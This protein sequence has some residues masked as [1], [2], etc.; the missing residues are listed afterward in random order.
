MRLLNGRVLVVSV[1][2]QRG[3][4]GYPVREG[5]LTNQQDYD[6]QVLQNPQ[7]APEELV[8]IAAS[9][10]DLWNRILDH[11]SVYPELTVWI[12]TKQ[13]KAT[14]PAQ[15]QGPSQVQ[16][17][18]TAPYQATQGPRTPSGTDPA[19][20]QRKGM[21]R[22]LLYGLIGGGVALLALVVTLVLVLTLGGSGK[23]CVGT[24]E[25]EKATYQGMTISKNAE[26]GLQ[27]ELV[28]SP[29]GTGTMD[30]DGD[31]GGVT[32]V[33][34]PGGCVIT[35]SDYGEALHFELKGNKLVGGDD[36]G[37]MEFKRK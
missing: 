6:F 28:L 35:D 3:L 26:L 12:T 37:A 19:P 34:E 15:S 5:T 32:W 21:S 13:T 29:D 18:Q 1:L 20:A 31:V 36:D 25:F 27:M 30:V 24:W 23:T 7:V 10:P 9:R 8:R 2:S 14:V 16:P 22:G 11:P 33:E 4:A 17:Q